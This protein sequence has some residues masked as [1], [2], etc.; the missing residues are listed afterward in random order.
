MSKS[1][2]RNFILVR[3]LSFKTRTK[4]QMVVMVLATLL[5]FRLPKYFC[6][7]LKNI[8]ND[9]Y[10]QEFRIVWIIA[11]WHLNYH[12]KIKFLRL[13]LDAKI[14]RVHFEKKKRFFIVLVKS[15]SKCGN[16]WVICSSLKGKGQTFLV[17]FSQIFFWLWEPQ[18]HVIILCCCEISSHKVPSSL[19]L[20]SSDL[21]LDLRGSA[22]SIHCSPWWFADMCLVT[23]HLE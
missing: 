3:H 11:K 12:S 19:V 16:S 14:F 9:S 10:N 7:F 15:S 22:F 23:S 18:A 6:R 1:S 5:F 21:W 17:Q 20:P 2:G 8:F 13:H 4:Y